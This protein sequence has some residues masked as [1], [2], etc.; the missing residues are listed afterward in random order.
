MAR[1]IPP[2]ED[3]ARPNSRRRV[4]IILVAAVVLA[5]LAGSAWLWSAAVRGQAFEP[6]RWRADID[7]REGAR[8]R[9]A[10]RLMWDGT[11]IGKSRPE[12]VELLGE[13]Q[14]PGSLG[15]DHLV[16]WLA[17]HGDRSDWLVLRMGP[18][19]RVAEARVNRE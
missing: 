7:A 13:P 6:D 4:W 19:G 15:P 8:L 12:L 14:P 10:R 2:E 5:G 9:M 18:D 11:L 17:L 16:Y 3:V 1:S